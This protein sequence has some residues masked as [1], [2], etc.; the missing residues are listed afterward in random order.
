MQ[1]QNF[2]TG[3]FR[4]SLQLRFFFS[5]TASVSLDVKKARFICFEGREPIV[6]TGEI[7]PNEKGGLQQHRSPVQP[8]HL[9]TSELSS[10]REIPPTYG[11][12]LPSVELQ[13]FTNLLPDPCRRSSTPIPHGTINSCGGRE[14]RCA[15]DRFST[16]WQGCAATS[17]PSSNVR[18][19]TRRNHRL[20]SVWRLTCCGCPKA[21]AYFPRRRQGDKAQHY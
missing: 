10:P 15:L 4:P 6:T 9:F 21:S 8:T 11:V 1:R 2:R 18:Q 13:R 20:N 12:H 3:A 16:L 17:N 5:S 14:D 19:H 7:K